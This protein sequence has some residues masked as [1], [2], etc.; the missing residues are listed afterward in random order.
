MLWSAGPRSGWRKPTVPRARP[1]P[2]PRQPALPVAPDEAQP[3]TTSDQCQWLGKRIIRVK[4]LGMVN[5]IANRTLCPE[6]IQG[7]ARPGAMADALEP[8]IADGPAR[9]LQLAGLEEVARALEGEGQIRSAG[10]VVA[11]ALGNGAGVRQMNP[12]S[13]RSAP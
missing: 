2:R 10:Q 1:Q 7:A 3:E 9:Q 13:D 11:E 5:L 8:L 4:W 12:G 6:F